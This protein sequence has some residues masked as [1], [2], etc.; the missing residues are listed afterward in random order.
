MRLAVLDIGSNSVHLLVVDAHVGAPPLPA[1]SHKEVLRL[2][3]YLCEDG[4]IGTEGQQRLHQFIA[5][6]VE[7]AEDQGA[8]QILAFATSAVRDAP[9]GAELIDSINSQLGVTLNVMSGKDE[10]R[11]TFL[12]AR[13]WFGWSAGKILLL[14][15][16]GGSLEIAAGQDE[17]PQA[18]VSVPLGAGRTYADFLPDPIPS[19]EN[20]HNLRKHARAQI[21]KIAGKI[22]RVGAPDQVVGSS[23]TFRSLARIA[24]AA[25]SGDG[26][27]APRKLFR[28]DLS[29]IIDTLA[30]RTPEER[31]TLPGVSEARAGQVLAGAIVAE[32]AFTIF[33]ISVMN[34]SPWALRE[35]IIMRKLDL[36]DSSEQSSAMRVE[37]VAALD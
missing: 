18:A 15:I 30:S 35:G 17:Y 5:D 29:G 24:G 9:N 2:A 33:D 20:L 27:Y 3:E 34:I 23:K 14:D 21:G 32:A 8:E 11:V 1:T 12:A 16:G 25:P 31:A 37:Q 19:A 4:M 28:R 22:N 6:A 7:I 10:A 26:I 36:L 13:R